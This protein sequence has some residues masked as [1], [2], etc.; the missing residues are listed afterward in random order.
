MA[1]ASITP[2]GS[3]EVDKI[4]R[5]IQ[6]DLKEGYNFM[7]E[8]FEWLSDY[9]DTEFPWSQRE[10]TFTVDLDDDIN[11]A[12]I[13]DAGYR[14]R[15]SAVNVEEGTFSLTNFNGTFTASHLAK[16]A[17]EGKTNQIERELKRKGA[18]KVQA[19]ARVIGD[20]IYGTSVGTL[21]LTDTNFSG[22]SATATLHSA[23]G[24][25]T[26]TNAAYIADRF[27]TGQRVAIV[28][29]SA[30]QQFATVGAI[31]AGTPS[32]ALTLDAS[33][34]NSNNNLKIIDASSLENTTLAGTSYN[35]MP[36]GFL[37]VLKSDTV[38]GISATSDNTRWDVGFEDSTT[39]G[40]IDPTKLQKLDDS[41]ANAAP[42]MK[43]PS[44]YLMSQGVYRDL[45]DQQRAAVEYESPMG[46]EIDGSVKKKGKTFKKTR[47]VPP[48]HLIA[49]DPSRYQKLMLVPKPSASVNW[50]G[51]I[52]LINQEASL[53]VMN[54]VFGLAC[55]S[56]ASFGYY[57]GLTES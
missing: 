35:K 43:E 16:W 19:F 54:T 13:P 49:Y 45:V 48:G 31:V 55:R 50:N 15:P 10:V 14:A 20:A 24:D 53:F 52:D 18:K 29:G 1:A 21:A 4:W 22:T 42:G 12:A 3:S 17:D 56:R 27:R 9:P 2:V 28:D 8:E 41:V 26:I 44:V 39:G 38:H 47:R 23:F 25:T 57:S 6:G 33:L 36:V 32:I 40:R 5:K 30:L 46:M 37:D 7:V 11:V 51:G 34:T